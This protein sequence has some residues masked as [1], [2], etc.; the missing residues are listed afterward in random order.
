[1]GP[2]RLEQRRYGTL[3]V[4]KQKKQESIEELKEML[5]RS[6]A[7]ILS[8]YRGLTAAQ[9]NQLRNKLRP[10]DS[11]MLVAKNTLV[12]KSLEELGLPQPAQ[13]LQGPTALTMIFGDMGQPVRAILDFA[14][15]TEF[16][17]TKGGLMGAHLMSVP[18][19][20]MLPQLPATD[21]LRAQALGT[22]VSPMT[23]LV[24]VLDSAL[25]GLL[26]ALGSRADQLGEPSQA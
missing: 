20:L 13:L 8:D 4:S 26:Y 11:R 9:M 19:V 7:V 16:F 17:R 21:A 14:K 6:Q 10:L 15:E 12:L 2:Q 25:R 24:G 23:G 18:E 3:P 5:S 22:V 1:M